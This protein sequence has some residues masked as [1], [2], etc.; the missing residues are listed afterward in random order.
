[1]AFDTTFRMTVDNFCRV[2]FNGDVYTDLHDIARLAYERYD[3]FEKGLD[4]IADNV[5]HLR[6]AILRRKKKVDEPIKKKRIRRTKEQIAAD[7]LEKRETKKRGR[8]KE[9]TGD[10]AP[11]PQQR[12]KRKCRV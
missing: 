10:P 1:M 5:E 8:P 12:R 9:N 7:A 4:L 3:D 2:F 11:P 6:S